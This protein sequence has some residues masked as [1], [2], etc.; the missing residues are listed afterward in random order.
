[1]K[2]AEEMHRYWPTITNGWAKLVHALMSLSS[3]FMEAVAD[4]ACSANSAATFMMILGARA[5]TLLLISVGL[6]SFPTLIAQ[7]ALVSAARSTIRVASKGTYLHDFATS[8][9]SQH[10]VREKV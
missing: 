3:A 9:T 10:Y 2:T 1:M 8:T 5:G 7:Y 4:Y 6:A